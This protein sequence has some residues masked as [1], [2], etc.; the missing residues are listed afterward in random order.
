MFSV[1]LIGLS[2]SMDALTVSLSAGIGIRG[3]RRF[4]MVRA[5]FFFGLFQFIMPLLGWYLGKTVQAY[6][7]AYD[8]WIAFG[9]LAF[10]G[11]KMFIAGVTQKDLSREGDDPQKPTEDI[12]SVG[13]LLALSLATSIDA[14]AV[15]ISFNILG[16]GIW[17]SSAIIGG[18]TFLVC[19]S[20]FVFGKGLGRFLGKWAERAGGL[21]LIAIGLKILLEHLLA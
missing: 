5:A 10:I 2:L 21:M 14:L 17:S 9:L 8:H 13:P 18:I 20:G 16:Q 1:I 12:R 11:G 4:Y 7:T 3:L 15:G 19:L 6:I